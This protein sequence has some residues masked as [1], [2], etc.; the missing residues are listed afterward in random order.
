[1]IT[2]LKNTKTFQNCFW[3]SHGICIEKVELLLNKVDKNLFWT[4][5][6]ANMKNKNDQISDN[7]FFFSFLLLLKSWDQFGNKLGNSWGK[8]AK[9]IGNIFFTKPNLSWESR[10][11]TWN[12]SGSLGM[13]VSPHIILH[14]GR[15]RPDQG[16][17]VRWKKL[18]SIVTTDYPHCSFSIILCARLPRGCTTTT[19]PPHRASHI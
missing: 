1:M 11:I 8:K 10:V 7:Y 16:I 15:Y 4:W 12:H 17:W 9:T 13:P 6:T 18:T 14:Q 3:R 2:R 19:T 5:K